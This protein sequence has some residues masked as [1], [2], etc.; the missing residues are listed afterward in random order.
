MFN[1]TCNL[2][3]KMI[4]IDMNNY[5]ELLRLCREIEHLTQR[6]FISQLSQYSESF[7]N[8]NTVTL[9]RWE[10]EVTSPGPKK[11]TALL[12]YIFSQGYLKNPVCLKLIREAFEDLTQPIA[13]SLNHHYA[14][15]IG[16]LPKFKVNEN[17]YHFKEMNEY[18]NKKL[19]YVI[20]IE[21][22]GCPNQYYTLSPS[23]L[24]DWSR[25]DSSFCIACTL[26]GEHLGHI[27]MLKLNSR[28]VR[29]L[30][31]NSRQD[32]SLTAEELLS[33]DEKGTYYVHTFYSINSDVAAMLSV[34]TYLFLLEQRESVAN[35]AT[36]INRKDAMRFIKMY[37]LHLV[38]KG[39]DTDHGCRWYGTLTS[40]E[41]ILFS[42]MVV[43]SIF[44]KT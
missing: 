7:K 39:I 42:R 14:S 31:H 37:G 11:K 3:L 38:D 26:D 27:V 4:G 6:E 10:N 21:T 12:K 32:F 25:R 22:A 35:I 24:R 9:S 29:E 2:T 33:S 36:F 28:T 13:L 41:D 18:S 34:K 17:R 16:N 20:D 15:I 40:L 44:S 5:G 30:V 8:L 43:K 23:I 19:S 1:Q